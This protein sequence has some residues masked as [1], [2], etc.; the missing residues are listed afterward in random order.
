M[1]AIFAPLAINCH[2]CAVEE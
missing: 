2:I 1:S